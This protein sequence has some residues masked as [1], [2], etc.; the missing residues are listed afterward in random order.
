[1]E[2]EYCLLR[3]LIKLP[4]ATNY[5]EL[6]ICNGAMQAPACNLISLALKSQSKLWLFSS[7]L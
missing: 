5:A 4:L 6:C 1:M 3:A 2:V 7:V